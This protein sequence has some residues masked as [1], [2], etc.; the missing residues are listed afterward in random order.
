[1]LGGNQYI[2]IAVDH[3]TRWVKAASYPSATNKFTASFLLQYVFLQ[4]GS[5]CV[6]FLGNS[7]NFTSQVVAKTSNLFGTYPKSPC[8]TTWLKMRLLKTYNT[9]ISI[10]RKMVSSDHI[11]RPTYPGAAL[12]AYWGSHHCVIGMSPSKAL[13][14]Q[15]LLLSSN[16]LLMASRAG[17]HSANAGKRLVSNELICLQSL[18][19]NPLVCVTTYESTSQNNFHPDPIIH[20]LGTLLLFYHRRPSSRR[21]NLATI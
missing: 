14:G 12:L 10:L 11:H 21:H 6:L 8:H 5:T 15:Y 2:L 16:I 7:I 13:Y 9:F 19:A 4:H 17:P 18:A 20:Q 3:L 1:M